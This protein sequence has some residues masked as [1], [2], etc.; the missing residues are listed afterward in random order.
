M[1]LLSVHRM[2]APVSYIHWQHIPK[3][4]KIHWMQ[5]IRNLS[6]SLFPDR[7][8]HILWRAQR[9]SHRKLSKFS[10][11]VFVF[12]FETVENANNCHNFSVCCHVVVV[13]V[14]VLNVRCLVRLSNCWFSFYQTKA[15]VFSIFFSRFQTSSMW[16]V[17]Q[18]SFF[19]LFSVV[20]CWWRGLGSREFHNYK[21][22]III[23][24]LPQR[25]NM[26]YG[27]LAWLFSCSRSLSLYSISV[28][29]CLFVFWF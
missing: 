2:W 7:L 25:T 11:K 12:Q 5:N 20:F 23:F 28:V 14:C 21:I 22:Q 29:H 18:T 27:F 10:F 9:L 26:S 16:L 24:A 15:F 1:R 19:I 3:V 4:L 6:S 17:G 8:S 13:A